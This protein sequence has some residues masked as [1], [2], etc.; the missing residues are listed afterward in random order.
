MRLLASRP[1]WTAPDIARELGVSVR[2]IRRDLSRLKD[3]GVALDS[4][5]GRGGGIRLPARSG[6]GRLQL[7]HVEAVDL[8]LALAIVERQRSP[9]LL[10]TLKG[11]RQKLAMAFP[12]EERVRVNGLR[13]RI[14][15]GPPASRHIVAEWAEPRAHVL[16][17]LHE[18]FFEQRALRLSYRGSSG[19][20]E[21]EVEPHYLLLSWPVWYLLAR[22]HL[23]ADVRTLRIDRIESARVGAESFRLRNSETM[24]R[25]S[26]IFAAL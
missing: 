22:D 10:S 13:R 8:L 7:S 16:R 26:G 17:P 12:F 9:V 2:T 19:L 21:R 6:I 3:R 4:E 23:R 1:A 5:P 14:L 11:L 15:I 24:L 25:S 18:A 20:T